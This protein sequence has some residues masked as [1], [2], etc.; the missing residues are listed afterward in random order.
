MKTAIRKFIEWLDNAHSSG[1]KPTTVDIRSRAVE[2]LEAEKHQ[3][4][5]AYKSGM[6]DVTH[7]TVLGE[8]KE[9]SSNSYFNKTFTENLKQ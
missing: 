9:V 4:I 3:I 6:D 8:I 7:S 1:I 2:L 5:D